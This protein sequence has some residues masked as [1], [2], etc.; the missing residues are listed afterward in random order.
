MLKALG[1]SSVLGETAALGQETVTPSTTVRAAIHPAIGIA[2]VGNSSDEYFIGPELPWPTEAPEGGYKDA[3]GALRR[4]AARF[5]IYGYD[6]EGRVTSELTAGNASIRWTV[7]IANKKA[8]WYNFHVALDLPTATPTLRRNAQFTGPQRQGLIIDGGGRTISGP[9]ESGP[10]YLFDTGRFL[11]RS[12]YLGELRT[13]E[14]GRLLVLGGPGVAGPVTHDR[15]AADFANNEGWFDDIAD[16]SVTAEVLV[17]GQ[18]IPVD[19]AWIVTCPPNYAPDLVSIQTMY[20]VVYDA[21]QGNLLKPVTGVSFTEH[22]FPLLSQMSESQWVNYGFHRR[23]GWG[24]QYEFLKP[25]YLPQLASNDAA[26]LPVRREIFQ[27]FRNPDFGSVETLAW[28][29]IYGDAM[30][31]PSSDPRQFMAVTRTQYEYLRRWADGDFSS[32]LEGSVPAAATLDEVPLQDRPGTL[33]KAALYFCSGG[34]FHP[35][36]EMTWPMRHRTMYASPFR[37]RHRS[38]AEAEPDYGHRVTMSDLTAALSASS[39]GDIT[40]WMAVPWQTDAASCRA[41]YDP[42]FDPYLPAFWPARVPNHV[43]PM[44]EYQRVLDTSLSDAERRD[45]F[46]RRAEWYRWLAG[47]YIRQINQMVTDF[48]RMGVV[49]RRPGPD[50]GRFPAR[51]YVES[52]VSF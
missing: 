13:D 50:D 38:A 33:D 22:I 1:W 10:S 49:Q 11:G 34:P 19:P 32:D 25:D 20:D 41:G 39:P 4:Q 46:E 40:R 14:K 36:C 7:H 23:F 43:L 37:L 48:G 45:A 29:P 35:G 24:S 52:D 16:G 27:N 18:A 47:D 21:L 15:P 5:R 8:A 3:A 28:P 51:M 6:A 26:Y 9:N 30:D 12:V 2:R 17:D 44:R 42:S 31:I